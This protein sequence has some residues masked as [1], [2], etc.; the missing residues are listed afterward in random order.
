MRASEDIIK[1]IARLYNEYE[2]EVLSA[3]EKGLLM[4]N[5]VRTYLL[6]SGNF[7]KWCRGNFVPGGKNA[8]K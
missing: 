6:H 4:D 2:Q 8:S 3:K 5:T 7:V 1:E